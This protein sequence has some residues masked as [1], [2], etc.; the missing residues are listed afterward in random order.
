MTMKE[1]I[2]EMRKDVKAVLIQQA[3]YN[4][5]IKNQNGKIEKHDKFI[6]E[7]H[8]EEHKKINS[9]VNRWLGGI[10]AIVVIGQIIIPIVIVKLIGG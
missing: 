5:H 7:T 9:T 2:A 6:T 3:A 1:D 10:T 4:E 8:P